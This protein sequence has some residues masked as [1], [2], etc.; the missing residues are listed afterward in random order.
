MIKYTPASELSLQ[1]FR[2][3]FDAALS[4]QNRWVR[5]ADLVPWDEMATVFLR[6]MSVAEG[7]PSVD[8]RT[9]LG[10]LL[11]KHIENLSDERTIEYIQE[12]IY[13]Q[14]FV[15]LS[16]FQAEPV[17]VPHLL[18]TIRKRL[19][20]QG[21]KAVNDMLI[22]QA[23]RLR[24][25]KHRTRPSDQVPPPPPP[26]PPPS[27]PKQEAQQPDDE[28]NKAV[29][30]SAK[31]EDTKPPSSPPPPRNRGTLI[32]D[33]TV[34]PVGIAYPTDSRLLAECRRI[35]EGLIDALYM[36]DR[37]LWPTKPRTYRREAK[38][39][40][41]DFS[42]KRRKTKREIRRQ[43]KKQAAYVARNVRTLHQMLDRLECEGKRVNWTHTQ[44]RQF[45]IV[46]EVLRQQRAMLRDGRRRI[47]DRIVSVVQP[48]IRP[49]KRGKGGTK[50]TEFG[51]KINAG[52][53]EGF[54]RADQIAFN[55]FNESEGLIDQV[56][57]YRARFGYYP[58]R[59]LADKIYWTHANR[60]WL[61]ARKID[62]GGVPLGRKRAQTK[63][64]K[65]K[66]QRKNN[67]RSEVEGKFGEAKERYGMDRLYTR[68]PQTTLAEISLILLSIN[69]V[70]LLRQAGDSLFSLFYAYMVT[71][72][73]LYAAFRR[74]YSQWVPAKPLDHPARSTRRLT[75]TLGF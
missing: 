39:S 10:T 65:E 52:L 60:K 11:V 35:A 3:P 57:G 37:S 45:W 29:E 23:H 30:A 4:P 28:H 54:V 33:A 40:E 64:Q 9:V 41:I 69:L 72:G 21:S 14:Y 67:Q 34:A 8:L 59:V 48:H 18:V 61:K 66:E 53:T 7:R 44:R 56:E 26:P 49:I 71:V 42:K 73:A 22:A 17:F 50:N 47:D 58:G 5:M 27:P 70:K 32:V 36:S 75:P 25:I 24:V 63:Y 74:A 13:A 20:E 43:V 15:G 12:N 16:S 51:P 31:A 62:I 6:S 1:L 68:L 2:T 46:Q 38:R 19:G 55:A